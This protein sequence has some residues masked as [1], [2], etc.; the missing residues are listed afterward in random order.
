MLALKLGGLSLTTDGVNINFS[1]SP[2]ILATGLGVSL[3]L[4]ILAGL[5]PAWQASRRDIVESFRA[6]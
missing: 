1:A 2:T 3:A 4:G 5:V 6:V